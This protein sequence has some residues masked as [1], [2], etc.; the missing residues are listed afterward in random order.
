[1]TGEE[2]KIVG[3]ILGFKKK[4]Q[5]SHHSYVCMVIPMSIGHCVCPS[6][7]TGISTHLHPATTRVRADA[8]SKRNE[9]R[10]HEQQDIRSID[11][12]ALVRAPA[13]VK[14]RAT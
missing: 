2:T 4:P 14:R 6:H 1:M 9:L 12:R 7:Y 5:Q 8:F 13:S 10:D 11:A 3:K